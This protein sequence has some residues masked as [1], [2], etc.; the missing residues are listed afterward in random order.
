MRRYVGENLCERK[1]AAMQYLSESDEEDKEQERLHRAPWR[2]LGQRCSGR[3]RTQSAK[4]GLSKGWDPHHSRRSAS[5]QLLW[6]VN[7]CGRQCAHGG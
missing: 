1:V 2:P 5:T 3:T 4:Y 7:I 6:R